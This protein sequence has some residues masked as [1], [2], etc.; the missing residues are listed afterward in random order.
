M[1]PPPLP[2]RD[3]NGAVPVPRPPEQDWLVLEADPSYIASNILPE[4]L[5]RHLGNNYQNDYQ[6]DVVQRANPAVTIYKSGSL[7]QSAQ[8]PSEAAA[9]VTL[10]DVMPQMLV[11]G[12]FGRGPRPGPPRLAIA[13]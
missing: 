13:F 9:S 10:F 2:S 5:A 6:I 3:R 12:G 1:V 7:Q 4:L 8:R 11:R